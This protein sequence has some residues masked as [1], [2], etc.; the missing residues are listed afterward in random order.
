MR[1]GMAQD[2]SAARAELQELMIAARWDSPVMP[3]R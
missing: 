2:L 3:G 1:V